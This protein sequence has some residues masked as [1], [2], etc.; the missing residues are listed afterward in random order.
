MKT[1]A[2][3]VSHCDHESC[4]LGSFEY[5]C[6][7]CNSIIIDY[8]VWWK[9]DEIYYGNIHEFNCEECKMKLNV[10]WDKEDCEYYVSIA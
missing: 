3:F 4:D 6:P 9:Q 7:K 8:E 2:H 1:E 10:E 5:T